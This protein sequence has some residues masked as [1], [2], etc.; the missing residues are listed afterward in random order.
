VTL[1]VTMLLVGACFLIKRHYKLVVRGL[2]QLDE[3]LPSPPEVEQSA[4]SSGFVAGQTSGLLEHHSANAP[5]P[6]KPVAILM[7]GGYSGLGRHA[8]LTLLRMFPQHFERVVFV[9]VAVVDSE[10][11][12]GANE[13]AAL[14]RRTRE[15]LVLY[16]RYA[17]TLGVRSTSALAMGTEVPMEAEKIAG[18][19]VCR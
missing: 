7:V 6:T 10:S 16:E 1:V 15:S 13:V 5:D 3:E 19:L 2:R 4:P 9:S 8:L 14:E 12:K 11:F 18:D 17:E